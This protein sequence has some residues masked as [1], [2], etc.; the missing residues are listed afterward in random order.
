MKAFSE[1]AGREDGAAVI[2]QFA[3]IQNNCLR[4]HQAFRETI[5]QHFYNKRQ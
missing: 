3:V 2:E 1:A 5:Q 4:C